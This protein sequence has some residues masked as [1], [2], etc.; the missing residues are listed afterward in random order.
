MRPERCDLC[1]V[2]RTSPWAGA[3][4]VFGGMLE[5]FLIREFLVHVCGCDRH[6]CDARRQHC[7]VGNGIIWMIAGL[8][9]VVAG[10]RSGLQ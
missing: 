7:F 1:Y 6:G 3:G 4:P 10:V 2:L 5:G 8:R 9:G